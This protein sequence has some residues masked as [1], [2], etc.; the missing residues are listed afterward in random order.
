MLSTPRKCFS[1]RGQLKNLNSRGDFKAFP[2]PFS[3]RHL[4][5][6]MRRAVSAITNVRC[7][8]KNETPTP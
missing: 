8:M 5:L 3:I 6:P 4:A 1:Q 2:F 7:E